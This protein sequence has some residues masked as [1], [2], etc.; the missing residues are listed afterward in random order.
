MKKKPILILK[1]AKCEKNKINAKQ[2]CVF[3]QCLS[4]PTSPHLIVHRCGNINQVDIYRENSF[5]VSRGG[6]EKGVNGGRRKGESFAISQGWK[7]Q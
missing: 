7:K 1:I 5:T 2:K 4:L 3:S 6:R